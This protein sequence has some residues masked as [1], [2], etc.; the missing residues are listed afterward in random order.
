MT[1]QFDTSQPLNRI[2][3]CKR[4]KNAAQRDPSSCLVPDKVL[5][6]E[7]RRKCF[8]NRVIMHDEILILI[9]SEALGASYFA[10]PSEGAYI[11]AKRKIENEPEYN[12]WRETYCDLGGAE[13]L[14]EK[15]ED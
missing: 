7:I 11:Y 6:R 8:K 2:R 10:M 9:V 14:H 5:A 1:S 13:G 4:Q 3:T 12:H 15:H